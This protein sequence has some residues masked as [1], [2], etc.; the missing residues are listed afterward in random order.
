MELVLYHRTTTSAAQQIVA[1]GFRDGEGYYM[2]ANLHR[3]V[4]LSDRPLD[5]NEG[6]LGETLLRVEMDCTE[7][8]IA[9]WE[10]VEEGRGY[11]EWLVPADIVNDLARVRIDPDD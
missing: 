10:W 1:E 8:D 9:K 2:T 3:G 11:R 4:W 5:A 7:G 6:T